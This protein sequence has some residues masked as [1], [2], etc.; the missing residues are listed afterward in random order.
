[1]VGIRD[2]KD[3]IILMLGIRKEYISWKACTSQGKITLP[4]PCLK[5]SSQDPVYER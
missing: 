5:N 3:A 4:Y 1:M 2:T